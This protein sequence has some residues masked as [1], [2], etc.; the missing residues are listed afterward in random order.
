MKIKI[1]ENIIYRVIDRN[2][3]ELDYVIIIKEHMHT[4][5]KI[6]MDNTEVK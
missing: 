2:R 3:P 1:C 6:R 5:G 4:S